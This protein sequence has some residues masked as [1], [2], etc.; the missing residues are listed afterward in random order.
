MAMTRP[1]RPAR[2]A[3]RVV[4]VAAAALGSAA[5]LAQLPLASASFTA[6][7]RSTGSSFAAA[8]SFCPGAG[9]ATTSVSNDTMVVES[10]PSA[11]HE[12]TAPLMVR[13]R[14]GDVRR[15]F[16]RPVLPSVPSRC[17]ITRATLTFEVVSYIRRTYEVYRVGSPWL[18]GSINWSNQPAPTGTPAVA[19][20][21][22]TTFTI[23]VTDQVIGL[24]TQGNNGLTMRDSD[25]STPATFTNSYHSINDGGAPKLTVTWS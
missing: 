19:T 13:A 14:T 9:S 16:V 17:T 4:A 12:G 18:I 7:T 10:T 21:T 15:M 2:A 23:D 1:L 20:T 3:A 11:N 22:D 6:T 24:Y 25:E 8:S 5:L